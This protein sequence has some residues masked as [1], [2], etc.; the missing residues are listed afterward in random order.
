MEVVLCHFQYSCVY[1]MHGL[2]LQV[3]GRELR[4]LGHGSER[5]IMQRFSGCTFTGFSP[6]A[7]QSSFPSV[8]SFYINNYG[9]LLLVV[10]SSFQWICMHGANFSGRPRPNAASCGWS[11][12]RDCHGVK[13]YTRFGMISLSTHNT[14]RA[15]LCMTADGSQIPV[16][17]AAKCLE[18][19]WR[20]DMMAS[21]S[22]K[23]IL[24]GHACFSSTM[25]VWVLF[26]ET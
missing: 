18:Y 5:G 12:G 23:G 4:H 13:G 22:V 10:S 9:S 6:L 11:Y 8:S 16:G 21:W 2:Q 24:G 20:G 25:G 7:I 15:W 1:S 14:L 19:W 3:S 17:N 26:R